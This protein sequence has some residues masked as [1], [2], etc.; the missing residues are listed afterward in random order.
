MA[1]PKHRTSRSRTH[2][3]RSANRRVE[4]APQSVCPTCGAAKRPHVVCGNCGN[5][6]GR[7]VLD[8]D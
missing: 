6:R 5:Y 4:A 7:Q 3:R 1:V 2:S 8:V